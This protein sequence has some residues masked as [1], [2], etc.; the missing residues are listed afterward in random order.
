[1]KV[2]IY[3]VHISITEVPIARDIK[4]WFF[5]HESGDET[6]MRCLHPNIVSKLGL[7]TLACQHSDSNMTDQKYSQ[8]PLVV[9]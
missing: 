4:E 8:F 9:V 7:P 6:Q 3:R 2:I 5:V 1:L